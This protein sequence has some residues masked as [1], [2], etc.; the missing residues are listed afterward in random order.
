MISIILAVN[1]KNCI[2]V[3]YFKRAQDS[4]SVLQRHDT[5][6]KNDSNIWLN[7]FIHFMSIMRLDQK[8][9]RGSNFN[10]TNVWFLSLFDQN[11]DFKDIL[12]GL[13]WLYPRPLAVNLTKWNIQGRDC[14]WWLPRA[15]FGYIMA[16][17][18]SIQQTRPSKI[19]IL[20]KWL[21]IC[22]KLAL[23]PWF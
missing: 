12:H 9:G 21:Q 17:K 19:E 2:V 5:V 11:M 3:R 18:V 8:V 15:R 20:S 6:S 23:F 7:V 22:C 14:V 13:R 16:L 10:A 4:T 1:V